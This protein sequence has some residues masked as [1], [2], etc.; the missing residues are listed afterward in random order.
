MLALRNPKSLRVAATL[1]KPY[2]AQEPGPG[3]LRR[4]RKSLTNSQSATCLDYA[5]DYR[6]PAPM[7]A[8]QASNF[9]TLWF[10]LDN[11]LAASRPVL[12]HLG[13]PGKSEF[14]W[15]QTGIPTGHADTVDVRCI[16]VWMSLPG[17]GVKEEQAERII[18]YAASRTIRTQ[19]W[20]PATR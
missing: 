18:A 12:I 3:R 14:R 11:T 13:E 20:R 5:Q 10:M 9:A 16:H 19:P 4:L 8:S 2:A 17:C 15:L 1:D 6:R 7:F